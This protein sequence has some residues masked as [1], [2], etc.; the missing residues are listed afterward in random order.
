MWQSVMYQNKVTDLDLNCQGH[1][2][3]IIS[4]MGQTFFVL[5]HSAFIFCMYMY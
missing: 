2:K 4:A 1:I 5:K 3:V